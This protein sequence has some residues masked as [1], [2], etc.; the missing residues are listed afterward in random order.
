MHNCNCNVSE[1]LYSTPSREMSIT[2]TTHKAENVRC[3][4]PTGAAN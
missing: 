1:H 2:Y 4:F 3:G